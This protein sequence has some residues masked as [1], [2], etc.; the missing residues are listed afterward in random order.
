ME[1]VALVADSANGISREFEFDRYVFVPPSI[2]ITLDRYPSGDWTFMHATTHLASDGIGFTT[3][4]LADEAG[5]IGM[6][7]QALLVEA[8]S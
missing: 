1:R 4:T 2:V 7:T 3:C 6:A 5:R 8:R